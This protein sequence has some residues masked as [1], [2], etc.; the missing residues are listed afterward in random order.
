M[1]SKCRTLMFSPDNRTLITHGNG[2]EMYVWDLN[3]RT[4]INRA[5]D[6]GCISC[7]S[8]AVSPS[9]QFIATGSAQGVVNL[10]NTKNVLENQSPIPLK[11]VMNEMKLFILCACS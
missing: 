9:G 6:D 2:S 10:Y 1:N 11:I 4:C 5:T 3:T 7:V 8:L